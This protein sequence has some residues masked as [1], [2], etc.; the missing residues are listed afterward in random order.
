MPNERRNSIR[1]L[2]VLSAGFV[3][4]CFV[5]VS[6]NVITQHDP[7]AHGLRVAYVGSPVTELFIQR[8]LSDKAPGAFDLRN[9]P[10]AASARRAVLDRSVYA[11]F[12]VHGRSALL[13]SASAA[14]VGAQQA[15]V[16]A[17]TMMATMAPPSVRVTVTSR[18]LRPL[19]ANDSRGLSSSAYQFALL[20]TGFVFSILLYLVGHLA[21]L[22]QRLAAIALYVLF[23]ALV[24]AL[25]VGP[26]IGA[27]RGH[28]LALLAISILFSAAIVLASYGL[29]CLFGLAGTGLSAFVLIL[30]GNSTAGGGSNQEFLPGFFRQIG[31]SL[32]NAA[33]VRAIR[34]TIYFQSNHIRLALVVVGLWV[35]GGLALMLVRPAYAWLSARAPVAADAAEA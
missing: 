29:E 31:Q 6:I 12:I 4:V 17:F 13:L 25:T 3:A 30:V 8:G 33:A 2:I 7:Q 16:N 1:S 18:D 10:D 23:A 32:P 19:P 20:V 9:Y 14:G 27:L 28:F 24:G 15:I 5:F 11:A 21:P 26:L 35:A 22:R 34:N